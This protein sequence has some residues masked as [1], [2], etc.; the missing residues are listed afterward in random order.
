MTKLRKKF[1]FVVF[2]ILSLFLVSV[3][4][5]FSYMSYMDAY[6]QV[7]TMLTE[8]SSYATQ[9]FPLMSQGVSG[10]I[11][12]YN[13]YY[14]SMPAAVV[15]INREG[16]VSAYVADSNQY[17][18]Q[19]IQEEVD[20][21]EASAHMGQAYIGN[22]LTENYAY[23]YLSPQAMT[24][25]KTYRIRRYLISELARTWSAV[26][27]LEILVLFLSLR[28]TRWMIAPIEEMFEKQKQFIADSSHELKTPLAV[29]M[30]SA[31]AYQS[32]PNPK[33]ID[34][35]QSESHRMSSLITRMLDLTKSENVTQLNLERRNV[36]LLVE[37]ALLPYE[38]VI[39][40][41]GFVLEYQIEENLYLECD[42]QQISQI[43][44]ILLDNAMQ[45]CSQHGRIGLDLFKKKDEIILKV[46]NEGKPLKKG[47]EEKIFERFYRED[48]SRQRDGSHY[49]LGLAIAKNIAQAHNA[50][51][52]AES[53]DGFTTFTVRFMRAEKKKEARQKW[54]RIK[55]WKN[56]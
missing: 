4:S 55:R 32:D 30:A 7:S 16:K 33:W 40:E 20:Q 37:K 27:F 26:F 51:I 45:H 42:D 54:P 50:T 2:G 36:S 23:T 46:F 41:K 18:L 19:E 48:D 1:F 22:L 43:V 12:G 24:I 56:S 8:F 14:S 47:T 28:M 5:L 49:G 38:S 34:N 53:K 3:G 13:G 29:I 15:F 10:E 31:E 35:I 9:L 17:T 6:G 25:L 21:I 44:V 11:D 52:Q 39:F